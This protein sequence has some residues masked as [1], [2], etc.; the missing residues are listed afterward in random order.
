M[1]AIETIEPQ[2]IDHVLKEHR[3]YRMKC[4]FP[5]CQW[6]QK[7]IIS[8]HQN[9]EIHLHGHFYH[10]VPIDF[11][12]VD[13]EQESID[14]IEYHS[15]PDDPNQTVFNIGHR[16]SM[17]E[18]QFENFEFE[19]LQNEYHSLSETEWLDLLRKCVILM[20]SKRAKD[21]DLT[22]P[23]M[24]ALK[25]FCDFPELQGL[26][27]ACYHE[28]QFKT[29]MKMQRT[30]YH[31]NKLMTS[32]V[33][34]SR[35]TI[36]GKLYLVIINYDEMVLKHLNVSTLSSF[37]PL[38]LYTDDV[39]V[40]SL[41]APV[42]IEVYAPFEGRGLDVSWIC[43][44]PENHSVLYASCTFQ[45]SNIYCASLPP[46][47][48]YQFLL[49]DREEQ[50]IKAASKMS[51]LSP[52]NCG[53]MFGALSDEE[54]V[55]VFRLLL[56]Q[57]QSSIWDEIR[58]VLDD[59]SRDNFMA[60]RLRAILYIRDFFISSAIMEKRV[61][62]DDMT[63]T[64]R[65]FLS[66]PNDA[67]EKESEQMMFE[68]ISRIFPNAQQWN[69]AAADFGL[70]LKYL[71]GQQII[72]DN[73]RHVHLVLDECDVEN[74]TRNISRETVK[75]M[76]QNGWKFLTPTD[77]CHF[78]TIPEPE[79]PF[80]S[81]FYDGIDTPN[82][83]QTRKRVV[84]EY[85][86]LRSIVELNQGV[87]DLE[88][89]EV[90]GDDVF[91]DKLKII[92]FSTNCC[93]LSS[94]IFYALDYQME[95]VRYFRMLNGEEKAEKYADSQFLELLRKRCYQIQ[96]LVLDPLPPELA[97]VFGGPESSDDVKQAEH[98]PPLLSFAAVNRIFLN[99][100]DLF[101]HS[102]TFDLVICLRFVD[103]INNLDDSKSLKL[104][105]IHFSTADPMIQ[106]EFVSVQW[107][108]IEIGWKFL[109]SK[110]LLT[111]F[112][113]PM[114]QCAEC[115]HRNRTLMIGGVYLR[116]Y[117]KERK[118]GLCFYDDIEEVKE[119]KNDEVNKS[120]GN[121]PSDVVD[122]FKAIGNSKCVK[123]QYFGCDQVIFV[124]DQYGFDEL[125]QGQRKRLNEYKSAILKY[126]KEQSIDGQRLV[127][128]HVEIKKTMSKELCGA[129]K[130]VSPLG[131]MFKKL[132][133]RDWSGHVDIPE[134]G[135]LSDCAAIERVNF[136][137]NHF[138]S[139]TGAAVQNDNEYPIRM[140]K[141]FRTLTD[142]TLH[143]LQRDIEHILNCH[144]NNLT[145]LAQ[146]EGCTK[147]DN[148]IHLQRNQRFGTGIASD[149][150]TESAKLFGT[151]V[152]D[153]VLST[154]IVDRV[155]CI[156]RHSQTLK[157][158]D[159]T[160]RMFLTD[161]RTTATPQYAHGVYMKYSE[162]SP[163]HKNLVIELCQNGIYPLNKE[164]VD[165]F[166]ERARKIMET[167][168]VVRGWKASKSSL[169]DGVQIGDAIYLEFILCLVLYCSHTKFCTAFRSSFRRLKY[170]DTEETIRRR[171][172]DNF[173]W[174]G[175]Y[176]ECALIYF[177]KRADSKQRFYHG[178]S[179]PFVFDSFS[180]VF[181]IP[182]STTNSSNSAESFTK[183]HQGVV[184]HLEPKFTGSNINSRYIAVSK[185]GLSPFQ[186]EREFLVCYFCSAFVSFI[187]SY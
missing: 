39:I 127:A 25:L 37:G 75:M 129:N 97:P 6:R 61:P 158:Q 48:N 157:E 86:N 90:I 104:E 85:S 45:I 27:K 74:F 95:L 79:P 138:E 174:F 131:A 134:I 53:G 46:P 32:A 67:E 87:G 63:K 40:R 2:Q 44:F 108:L 93:N 20:Q 142:Y 18:A 26:L 35:D 144:Q 33:N 21:M 186:N 65:E 22:L 13:Q 126:F 60:T 70:F 52:Q 180:A 89:L 116:Q 91:D 81:L 160:F 171:H 120:D 150:T 170:D 101:L 50:M 162:L 182:T 143:S 103:F 133:A 31:F 151:N 132:I 114:W 105:R 146:G 9:K 58:I 49:L 43:S 113:S 30:F 68:T 112:T 3:E 177:G 64:V 96:T 80:I 154:L 84:S 66:F 62:L 15:I 109:K 187:P 153:D 123:L 172:A 122:R 17:I 175:R 118:C 77:I 149:V 28:K 117:P 178:L 42:V 102:T 7:S 72:S 78:G 10:G 115:F 69:V 12:Q 164:V 82:G 73:L 107:R 111:A 125:S 34:E 57:Y 124:L 135:S 99:V 181:E 110:Q 19:I 183:A 106:S 163:K 55:T 47:D 4:P 88:E 141:M 29:R 94:F 51:S 14:R 173:Y 168:A 179:A 119:Q 1:E 139:W 100:T 41:N 56:L 38:F 167:N 169:K 137:L 165:T 11:E 185:A 136:I 145:M 98:Y 156:F 130:L 71:S 5:D 147:M 148:C 24:V 128:K 152:I 159:R 83:P 121:V 161:I 166:I 76:R 8:H 36:S 184:L 176:L 59:K 23:Q 155:H 54:I 92:E 16:F 140:G